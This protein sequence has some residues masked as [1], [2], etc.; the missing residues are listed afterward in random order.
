MSSADV[1]DT[2]DAACGALAQLR[3]LHA[4]LCGED[5]LFQY[6]G[7]QEGAAIMVGDA[8][9]PLAEALN[10]LGSLIQE[11]DREGV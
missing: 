1:G 9:E 6:C 7:A 8:I 2:Y 4:A 5:G 10:A 3:F 11:S